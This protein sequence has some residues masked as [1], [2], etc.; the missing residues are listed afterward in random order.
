[1]KNGRLAELSKRSKSEK[2]NGGLADA[3]NATFR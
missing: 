1:M 2:P 3:E